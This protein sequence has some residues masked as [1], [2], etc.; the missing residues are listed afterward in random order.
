MMLVGFFS[1]LFIIDGVYSERICNYQDVVNHLNLTKNK[2]L[3]TMTRPVK[4][5]K[6][7]T[8]V[9]LE[10]LLTGILDVR[11]RNEYIS[12]DEKEFCGIN[13]VSLPTDTFWK[14]DLTIDEIQDKDKSIPTLYLSINNEGYVELQNNWIMISTCRMH[15]YK[16]PFDIQRCNL[17]FQSL[18]H[19]AKEIKLEP[20]DNS[21]EATEWSNKM[22]H[23]QNEW[24]FLNMT[25]TKHTAADGQDVIVFTI[26][27][28]RQS[29]L[30][31]I[32]F[33][34]PIVFFLFLDL[35]SFLISDSGGE[36]LSF[37]VT[38]LLAVTVLQ[39]LLN[40]ILPASSNRIPLIAVF[41]IGV[42]GL[43]LLSLLETIFIMRLIEKDV[44]QSNEADGDRSLSQ[45]CGHKQA[46]VKFDNANGVD[47][48]FSKDNCSYQYLLKYLNM[49][50]KNDLYSMSRPV[51]YYG[52][53][54]EVRLDMLI[55]AILDVLTLCGPMMLG[56][57]SDSLYFFVHRKRLSRLSFLTFGFIWTEENKAPASPYL[58][59]DSSGYIERRTNQVLASTCKM[60]VYKFPFDIQTCNISFKSNIYPG[61]VV[62]CLIY[63]LI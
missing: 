47:G 44:S 43:M 42:F 38:V 30:Y 26:T 50:S 57:F 11:W 32:N 62:S 17:S 27:M 56:R 40:E 13:N 8:N 29:V 7:S 28:K 6:Q 20:I 1:L 58:S 2:E 15:V 21:S 33:L 5:Y 3:Y 35:A 41:C 54:I 52:N 19:T 53:S 31:V 18:I 16:F 48:V 24:I 49:T 14:P 9:S 60:Q 37:K 63:T 59:I 55:Y 12:W 34:L 39:L 45:D 25:V 23:L 36:K 46:K 4:D 61:E 10:V 51:K 22:I